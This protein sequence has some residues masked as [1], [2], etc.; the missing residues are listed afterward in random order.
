MLD[1]SVVNY[2]KKKKTSWKDMDHATLKSA[3][4]AEFWKIGCLEVYKYIILL[5][6][7]K[8]EAPVFVF[9]L[10][11]LLKQKKSILAWPCIRFSVVVYFPVTFI[12]R[13]YFI[14][15]LE[16]F[17]LFPVL[18]IPRINCLA[19]HGSENQA[20][21]SIHIVGCSWSFVNLRGNTLVEVVLS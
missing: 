10:F 5:C 21:E 16:T 7:F 6:L 17:I 8:S 14:E 19:Q 3:H 1:F 2:I 4:L 13:M 20:V 12:D 18:K 11:S 9:N 15:T